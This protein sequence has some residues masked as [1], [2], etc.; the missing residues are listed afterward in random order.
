PP[1]RIRRNPASMGT[2]MQGLSTAQGGAITVPPAVLTN[3]VGSVPREG[4]G[5]FPWN[6]VLFMVRTTFD[7]EW[8]D[9]AVVFA[10]GGGPGI[11]GSPVILTGPGGGTI[12]YNAGTKSFGGAAQFSL[13]PGPFAGTVKVPPGGTMGSKV[14]VLSVWANVF[15]FL[16]SS[17]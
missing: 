9:A 12:T 14:P 7:Y 15:K 16:P 5:V 6:L 3:R 17:A 8:P 10:P 1:L 2:I 4:I 11:P 13:A